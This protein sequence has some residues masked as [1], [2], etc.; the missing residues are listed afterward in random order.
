MTN[1]SPVITV[2]TVKKYILTNTCYFRQDKFLNFKK[3]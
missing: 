2:G 3:N 1:Y